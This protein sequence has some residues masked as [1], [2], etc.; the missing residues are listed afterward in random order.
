M[1]SKALKSYMDKNKF[2]M[3]RKRNQDA[4]GKQETSEKS[5]VANN[6]SFVTKNHETS[7]EGGVTYNLNI[8]LQKML[9]IH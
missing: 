9:T 3:E 5:D 4:D 6:S 8:I 1:L 7:V 2:K